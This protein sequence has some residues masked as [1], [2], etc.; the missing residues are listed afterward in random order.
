MK[1]DPVKIGGKWANERPYEDEKV[2]SAVAK[3]VTK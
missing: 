2:E 3:N 1:D